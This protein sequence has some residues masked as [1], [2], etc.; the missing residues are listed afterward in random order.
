MLR[1]SLATLEGEEEFVVFFIEP[2]LAFSAPLSLYSRASEASGE[3]ANLTERK[4]PH[5]PY[6]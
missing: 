4:N 1:P 5:T 2:S 6:F 3:E